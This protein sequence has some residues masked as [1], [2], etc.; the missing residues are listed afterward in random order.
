MIT[1]ETDYQM[2]FLRQAGAFNVTI[3]GFNS[4]LH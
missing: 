2:P 3:D 1:D 4:T